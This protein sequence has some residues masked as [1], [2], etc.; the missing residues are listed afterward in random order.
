MLYSSTFSIM[1]IPTLAEFLARA[2]ETIIDAR[3]NLQQVTLVLGKNQPDLDSITSAIVFAYFR[4]A[5]PPDDCWASTY[6]P[7]LNESRA[8]LG[9]QTYLNRVLP[10]SSIGLPDLVAVEDMVLPGTTQSGLKEELV[11]LFF[12]DHNVRPEH[13]VVGCGF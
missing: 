8:E 4:S 5:L 7:I 13:T 3:T 6:I 2:K 10:H 9:D 11:R 1:P 12:V